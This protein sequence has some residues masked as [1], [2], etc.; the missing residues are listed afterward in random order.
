MKRFFQHFR[1]SMMGVSVLC[2]AL[3]VLLLLRPGDAIK[4]FCYGFGAVLILSGLLQIASYLVGERVGFMKKLLL[5]SGIIAA[6]VGVW[7][8]LSPGKVLTLTLIVLGIVFLYHGVMD[9]KYGCDIKSC[10]GSGWAVTLIFGLITCGLGVLVL[11]NPFETAKVLLVL[12]G[13]SLIFDGL[14]DFFTVFAVAAAK[15]KFEVLSGKEP[16]IEISPDSAE[17]IEP[18]TDK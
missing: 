5:L 1:F 4:L 8:V 13:L 3:G 14:T 17:M 7:V 6:V 11:V 9:I 2:I 15:K 16:V 10:R 18:E 12:I